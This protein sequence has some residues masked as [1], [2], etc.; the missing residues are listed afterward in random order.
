[1]TRKIGITRLIAPSALE[2]LKHAKFQVKVWDSPLPPSPKELID[3]LKDCQGAITMLSDQLTASIL[4]ELP[5]CRIIAN[6]AVGYNNIDLDYCKRNL[7]TVT[8][9]PSVLTE[10]TAE[11]TLSLLLSV[12]RKVR[13]ALQNV[14]QGQW[15]TWVPTGFLGMALHQKKLGIIGPG[16]LERPSQKNVFTLLI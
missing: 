13:P 1:M 5:N 16:R 14:L 6:Y 12:A 15:Q 2:K 8:N 3:H 7:V 10:A 4:K 11:L 9:T